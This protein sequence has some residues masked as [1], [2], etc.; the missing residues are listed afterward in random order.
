MNKS[1]IKKILS[2]CCRALPIKKNKIIVDNFGG[3]GFS[4][5][6]RYIVEALH[7]ESEKELDIVWVVGEKDWNTYFPS[8]VRKVNI[9]KHGF[10][11][12]LHYWLEYATSR[13][14]I[15]NI[16][17]FSKPYKRKGQFYLQT[18]HGAIALKKIEKAAIDTLTPEYINSSKKDSKQIDLIISNSQWFNDDVYK[19]FWYDGRIAITGTP[20]NDVFF[21]DPSPIKKKVR[22]FYHIADD[23]EFIL[24][25]PTFRGHLSLENQLSLYE[26]DEQKIIDAFSNKFHKKFIILKRLHPNISKLVT[27]EES[28]I[29]KDGS[30]YTNMQDLLIS[31]FALITDFSSSIFDLMLINDR[32]FLFTKDYENYIEKERGLNF[33]IKNDLPFPFA[34]TEN[35]LVSYIESFDEE[36]AKTS[37]DD[38][39]AK[40]QI[41]EDGHASDRVAKIILNEMNEV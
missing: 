2:Y 24:Y 13:V 40:L 38:F 27:M 12:L 17:N 19:N 29:I 4:D 31:C 28:E 25:A 22:S 36:R 18:W 41:K 3:R 1:F 20:R 6:P 35:E 39:K 23:V 9:D 15:D 21:E 30:R 11:S 14:W 7:K 10:F 33:D 34:E 16:K 37:I 32:I 5:N 26:F 8:Y